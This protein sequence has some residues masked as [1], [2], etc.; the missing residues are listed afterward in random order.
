MLNNYGSI[1]NIWSI[2]HMY[3]FQ[4]LKSAIGINKDSD[5]MAGLSSPKTGRSVSN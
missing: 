2:L 5:E 4:T 1:T 3:V